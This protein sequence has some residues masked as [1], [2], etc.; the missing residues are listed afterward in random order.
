MPGLIA[1]VAKT[2]AILEQPT[3]S[4]IDGHIQYE[5][6]VCK[7]FAMENSRQGFNEFGQLQYGRVFL[8]APLPNAP[9]L[10]GTITVDSNTYTISSIKPYRNLKG[11][12]LGY[13]IAVES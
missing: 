9:V 11:V 3:G 5:A 2:S 12:L 7:V 1:K 13:R 8:V 4:I 6:Y 10:P